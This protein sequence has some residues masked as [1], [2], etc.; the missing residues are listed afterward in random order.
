MWLSPGIKEYIS[1]TKA[2]PGFHTKADASH[3]LR[4][5][6]DHS[7]DRRHICLQKK[8]LEPISCLLLGW[9]PGGIFNQ[10][11]SV[12][13]M[14]GASLSSMVQVAGWQTVADCSINVP[15]CSMFNFRKVKVHQWKIKNVNDDIFMPYQ[16]G[17]V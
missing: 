7:V 2:S 4:S 10:P 12:R 9:P 17:T 14:T 3:I 8:K 16:C 15:G 5:S 1:I 6:V 13:R 11:S